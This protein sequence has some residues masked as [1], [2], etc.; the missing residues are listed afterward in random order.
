MSGDYVH[1]TA[2]KMYSSDRLLI[3]VQLFAVSTKLLPFGATVWT[4]FAFALLDLAESIPPA[5]G[6][7]TDSN[8]NSNSNSNSDRVVLLCE[9]VASLEMTIA[10]STDD[11]SVTDVIQDAVRLLLRSSPSDQC[12]PGGEGAAEACFQSM[13]VAPRGERY[14]RART[15]L[16]STL[17]S[18]TVTQALCRTDTG[19]TVRP[20]PYE[21]DRGV[22][23]AATVYEIFALFR[24]CGVVAVDGALD[25]GAVEHVRE[26]VEQVFDR[27]EE[28]KERLIRASRKVRREG[29]DVRVEGERLALRDKSGADARWELKMPVMDPPFVDSGVAD[30][31]LS[32]GLARLLMAGPNV[33]ID[34]LSTVISLP[35]CPVGHW[36][37]DVEDPF[38]YSMGHMENSKNNKS[39]R[40]HLPPPGV[41]AVVPLVEVGTPATPNNGPTEFLMGSHIPPVLFDSTWWERHQTARTPP[42]PSL[43]LTL[44]AF[45]GTLILFDVRLR[46]R[47]GANRSSSVRP[48]LYLG[49]TMRWFRD[50]ANFAEPHTVAW[51]KVEGEGRKVLFGRLDAQ[52][53]TRVLE[54][55]LADVYGVEYLGK[56]KANVMGESVGKKGGGGR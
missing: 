38:F 19:V 2:M 4:N 18:L 42:A 28:E 11:A 1:D 13:C 8:S 16:T 43:E 53:Y 56:I 27:A 33:V 23:S 35:G 3:A 52:E 37:G 45:P 40:R 24:F 15:A 9:A 34:T 41:I 47:G 54:R 5:T 6:D 48:I 14:A 26:A 36:H 49:Y 30:S 12:T 17:P 46:H 7:D 31:T 10:M 20:L 55:E 39:N 22:L 32:V 51:E 50:A 25:Q 44:P 21:L 29:G